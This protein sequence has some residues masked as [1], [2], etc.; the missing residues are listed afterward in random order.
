MMIFFHVEHD[1]ARERRS[2]RSRVSTR[3]SRISKGRRRR[4]HMVVECVRARHYAMAPE[5]R[6]V[7][8]ERLSTVLSRAERVS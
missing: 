1:S 4:A 5:M 6:R 3:W 2:G 8:Y 7:S